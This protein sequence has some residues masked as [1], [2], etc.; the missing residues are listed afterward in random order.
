MVST[1]ELTIMVADDDVDDQVFITE[2][3]Q[4]HNF[5]VRSGM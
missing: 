1:D 4:R 2:A 5:S 3:L